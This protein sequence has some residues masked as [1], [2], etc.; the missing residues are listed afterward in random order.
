MKQWQIDFIEMVNV[1]L[2]LAGSTR[3]VEFCNPDYHAVARSVLQLGIMHADP[4]HACTLSAIAI[5]DRHAHDADWSTLVN[6]AWMAA[7]Y[8][9]PQDSRQWIAR[10]AAKSAHNADE[11]WS[12]DL[13]ITATWV[14]RTEKNRLDCWSEITEIISCNATQRPNFGL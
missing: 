6:D 12:Q 5:A 4:D 8:A 3:R 10:A 1:G 14:A 13:A 11:G 7:H 9:G 2:K